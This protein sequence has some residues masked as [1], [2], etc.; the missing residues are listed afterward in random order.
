MQRILVLTSLLIILFLGSASAQPTSIIV[1]AEGVKK[2]RVAMPPFTGPAELAA[3]TW[4]LVKKDIELT[5]VFELID[6]KGYASSTP[7]G[8]VALVNLKDFTLIG[9]DFIITG[10][11]TSAGTN[12]TLRLEAAE[13]ATGKMVT[14]GAYQQPAAALYGGVHD[15][16]DRFLKDSLGLSGMFASRIVSVLQNG[17]GKVLYTC[18]SDGSAGQAILKGRPGDIVLS[19]AWSPDG[20]R[21]AFVSYARNNPDLYIYQLFPAR[22]IPLSTSRGLNSAPAFHP[23]GNQIALTLSKDGNQD[24]YLMN[25]TGGGLTRLT[26]SWGI[27]TSP[28]FSPDGSAL[29]FCSDNGGTPQIYRMDL[30]TRVPQRLTFQGRENTEPIYSPRGDLI[31]FTHEGADGRFRIAIIRPDGSGFM[32]LHPDTT[33]AEESACFSPDGRLITYAGSDGHLYV[34]DLFGSRPVRITNGGGR[35]SQP[36]W[37][38][39]M[40]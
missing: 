23:G 17:K 27:E 25:L 4:A 35:Y 20:Q 36:C 32:V 21:I 15:F 7:A 1:Q 34:S 3:S 39:Q 40:R 28:A 2:M 5:G 8:A 29:V 16:M 9:A 22:I 38:P 31:A 6:P 10:A 26:S 11:V 12:A 30:A 37:G 14:R 19:P 18:W 13:V 24:I 33:I